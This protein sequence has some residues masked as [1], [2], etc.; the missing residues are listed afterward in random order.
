MIT[1]S[2]IG[3]LDQMI[4]E[5]SSMISWVSKNTQSSKRLAMMKQL[6]AS[7]RRLKRIYNALK[8]N[9]TIAA[10]GESQQGK[11]YIISSLLTSTDKKTKKKQPL[12][13]VDD[14]GNK[15]DFIDNINMR[16]DKQESTGVVTR[17]TTSKFVIDS[18]Y[19]VKL[20]LLSAADFITILADSFM[21]DIT[22]YQPYSE[23]DLSGI[24]ERLVEKYS[25]R[26]EVQSWLTE[27]EVANVEE[28]IKK[29][30]SVPGAVYV[31]SG[32]F[33]VLSTII[34]RIPENEWPSVFSPLWKEDPT[35]TKFFSLYI[36]AYSSM[37]YVEDVFISIK[38]VLNDFNDGSPTLMC[39]RALDGLGEL[40]DS[41]LHCGTQTEVLLPDKRT[42]FI[43][44]SLLSAMT[45][46][47]VYNI[48]EDVLNDGME[49][50][51]KGIR[52]SI[53]TKSQQNKEMLMRELSIKEIVEDGK[54][55]QQPFKKSFLEKVDLLDFPGARGRDMGYQPSDIQKQIV[56]L[57][58]RC[59]V[60]YLFNKYSEDLKLSI[61]MF[62]HSQGN[63][64][65]NLVAPILNSWVNT[66]IGETPEKRQHRMESYGVPP[67]FLVST[68]YN[69]D[70]MIKKGNLDDKIWQRRLAH[71]W[72]EEV[73]G[74]K[75]NLWFDNWMPQQTFDNT[76]LLRDYFYSSDANEGNKIF[77]GWPNPEDG[78][79]QIEERSQL[80]KIFLQDS[81]VRLFFKNPEL[82][83][84][85]ASTI[86]NDGSYYILK[87]LAIVSE[88]AVDA[89]NIQFNEDI[90]Q[91]TE[92]VLSVIKEEFH[93]EK[94][95]ELLEKSATSARR[96]RFMLLRACEKQPDFFGRMIQFLQVNSNFVASYFHKLIH[97]RALI[98]TQDIKDYEM[99]IREVEEAGYQF[100]PSP[101]EAAYK[102]N[103]E[104]LKSVHGIT[105]PDD[106]MM[107]GVDPEALFRGTYKRNCSPSSILAN[108]FL[109]YWCENLLKPESSVLFTK[110]GFDGLIFSDFISNFTNMMEKTNLAQHIA[111]EI[112][113]YVD[114]SPTIQPQNEVMVADIATNMYNSFVMNMGYDFL[115]TEERK[116]AEE[117]SQKY[118]FPQIKQETHTDPLAYSDEEKQKL[119]FSQLESLNDG[120]GGQLTQLPAY[121]SMRQWIS[122][123]FMSF[124]VAYNVAKYDEAANK[125]LGGIIEN[126]KEIQKATA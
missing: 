2:N 50:C 45:A 78:E 91:I 101:G 125:A 3:Q 11:S 103:F 65:P 72:Y 28:Y 126:F 8:D 15:I 64:T 56:E 110:A 59:K 83:W 73:I 38:A 107:D 12:R 6:V 71:I 58:L 22:G 32:F 81:G 111:D 43:N 99:L 77:T 109:D 48:E 26:P 61:L 60:S 54:T 118:K 74:H 36:S 20:H 10:Y 52:D 98:V 112:K 18:H 7:R 100:D 44:K 29:H 97:S 93:D 37:G 95:A 5:L 25:E 42:L 16:T 49:F 124:T 122:Y 4:D 41:G 57:L 69:L 21:N 105:G 30:D 68:M 34:R 116:K 67:L 121:I 96:F 117:I 13:I 108:S 120:E 24:T 82:A 79:N 14:E 70:L 115:P 23:K 46:E 66:Y 31:N 19:P 63:T 123:V 55:V 84:N 119:L 17:F 33:D 113:E 89:R 1:K 102:A 80:K 39:V 88:K 27:D 76:F 106:P 104:I 92:N 87:R 114:Y 51:F 90:K 9:P 94:D 62:C 35:F 53:T 47:A 40:I 75:T 86:G 85:V